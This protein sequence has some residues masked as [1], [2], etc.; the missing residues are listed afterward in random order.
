MENSR[1]II[2]LLLIIIAMLVVVGVMIIGPANAKADVMITVTSNDTLQDGD[3]FSIS[4]TDSNGAPLADQTV[5]VTIYAAENESNLQQVTT[6]GMGNGMLQLNGLN[7]GTYDFNISYSGND[8]YSSCELTKT[9]NIEEIE[10]Q[11]E[12]SSSRFDDATWSRRYY[13]DDGT[14]VQGEV[15]LIVTG[16]GELWTYDNGEYYYGPE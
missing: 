10:Q 11:T 2:V 12:S 4:L 1:I 9:I 7:A 15:Y 3:Y 13:W 6:D 5:N 16:D 8:N 14:P